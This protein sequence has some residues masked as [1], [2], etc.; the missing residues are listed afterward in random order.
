M[1]KNFVICLGPVCSGKT[2]W[3][4][5]YLKENPKTIRFSTDEFLHMCTGSGKASPIIWQAIP[6]IVGNL[7]MRESVIVDGFPL[8]INL[9]RTLLNY[10]FTSQT[11]TQ[12]KLFDVKFNE[13]VRRN[14]IRRKKTGRHVDVMEMKKY[15]FSYK[16]FINSEDF[17]SITDKI[18][19][20]CDDFSEANL[21]LIL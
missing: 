21:S 11:K 3:S 1:N 14:L 17:N 8:D 7:L 18:E 5:E 15:M 20:I 9:F 16:E 19:V 4:L 13:A 10:R 6:S 12:I 2:T